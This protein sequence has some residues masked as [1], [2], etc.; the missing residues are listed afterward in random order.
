MR[1]VK[2]QN[3]PSFFWFRFKLQCG[4]LY[5]VIW[6]LERSK[7]KS[8]NPFLERILKWKLKFIGFN[9]LFQGS[10]LQGKWQS[11]VFKS[12]N[13]R[14]FWTSYNFFVFKVINAFWNIFVSL[15][16]VYWA[17]E[18]TNYLLENNFLECIFVLWNNKLLKL[19]LN[20]FKPRSAA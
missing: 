12:P 8:F 16:V 13:L 19:K 20:W 14:P 9:G 3:V 11:S 4:R 17:D 10:H 7:F 2:L 6:Q 18:K 15:P 1:A 5:T